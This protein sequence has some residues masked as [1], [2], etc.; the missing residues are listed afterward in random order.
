[1]GPGAISLIVPPEHALESVEPV[2]LMV[3]KG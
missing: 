1:M 3:G 2:G